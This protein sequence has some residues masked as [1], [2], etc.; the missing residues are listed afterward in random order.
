MRSREY[1]Q[2]RFDLLQARQ[3]NKGIEFYHNL[4]EQYNK[5][6][7]RIQKEINAF[8]NRFAENNQMT[9]LEAKKVLNARELQEFR[10]DVEEYIE[11]G[12]TLNYSD[13]WAKKLENA[14]TR[15]RV[16]RLEALKLQMQ[17]QVE[18][19]MGYE[20]DGLDKLTRN[21]YE[22][23]YYK[24]AYE[25]QKG[26][27]IGKSFMRLDTNEIDKIISRPWT[28]DGTNFSKRVWGKH[29]VELV[30]TL[31]NDLTQ[32]IIRG[33]DPQK[34]IN[35]IAKDFRVSKQ[36]AGRLVLTESAFFASASKKDSYEKLGVKAFRISATL[37]ANTCTDCSFRE[38]AIIPIDEYRIGDTAP[39]FHPRCRCT[40]FP[41]LA[42]ADLNDTRA[43]RDE[44]NKYTKVPADM[45][46]MQWKNKFVGENNLQNN[47]NKSIIKAKL[48]NTNEVIMNLLPN[49]ENAVIPEEKFTKYALNP[50]RDA[51][52]AVAFERALGYNLANVNELIANIKNN[53]SKFPAKLKGD[54]G[55][56]NIYELILTIEGAN[57]KK[58]KVLTGWIDDKRTGEMR[59]TTVHIDD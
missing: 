31:N 4:S 6:A 24:T 18:A 42:D 17:Q 21:V 2:K 8:Y 12:K 52:K 23:G 43:A 45:S 53:L 13:Q 29:R 39:P 30:K 15:Y 19:L 56:G 51:D 47:K 3:L 9:M 48:K 36:S 38:K 20:V 57:G 59:L 49:Y 26:I 46:Y 58:A 28:S 50:E 7:A 44:N 25:I 54:K 37:D 41:Y 16:T 33:D 5:A 34:L 32:A 11:K 40:T 10:W 1:W 35:K 22:D 14:S 55:Y 27:G